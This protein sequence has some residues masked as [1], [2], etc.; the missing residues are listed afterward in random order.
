MKSLDFEFISPAKTGN[1]N[2]FRRRYCQRSLHDLAHTKKPT[3]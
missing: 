1:Y 2:M 3:S